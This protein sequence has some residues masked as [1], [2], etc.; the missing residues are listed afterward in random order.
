[1]PSRSSAP[2]E[3]TLGEAQSGRE[4]EVVAGRAHRD[5][6][7][8]RL[9]PRPGDPHLHRLLGDELVGPAARAPARRTRRTCD[10]AHR[11]TNGRVGQP[12]LD[13][14]AEPNA[15]RDRGGAG[16]PGVSTSAN[17]FAGADRAPLRLRQL[18]VARR[19]AAAR[20]DRSPAASATSRPLERVGAV[21]RARVLQPAVDD[22][23][24]RRASRP[25]REQAQDRR[26]DERQVARE[27]HDRT[28]RSPA[29]ARPRP[30]PRAARARRILAHAREPGR[31]RADLDHRIAHVGRAR[32]PRAPRASHPA[33]RCAPCR[34]PCRRLAP[35]VSSTPAHVTTAGV[36]GAVSVSGRSE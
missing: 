31:A 35:P 15:T 17:V 12:A 34:S 33:T 32:A 13:V 2:G 27:Q 7:R 26:L 36:G 29:R 30:A 28:A 3:Q 8:R 24:H 6:E 10:V 9:L 22:R 18:V 11:T 1:M 25:V 5:R 16:R 20:S 21:A 23:D 14:R 19:P 4:L